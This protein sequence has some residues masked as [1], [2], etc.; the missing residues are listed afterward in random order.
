MQTKIIKLDTEKIDT[1]KVKEAAAV[2]D[3]GGLVAFPTETVYGIACQAKR[4]SLIRLNAIKKRNT[5]KPYSL[6][7]SQKNEVR[8]YVPTIGLKANKLIRNAWPGPLTIVF[9]LSEQD[10]N[11]QQKLLNKETIEN[12]YMNNSIGIRCPDNS[13]ASM[14]LHLV[15]GSVVAPSA[16]IADE[17]PATDAEQVLAKFSGQIELVLDAGPCRF[18]KSSTVVRIDKGKL[19]I[20]RS[21]FYTESDLAALSEVKFLFICTGNTCRSPMAEGIFRK[22]L[23]EK[24]EC[25]VDQLTKMGYKVISAGTINTVDSPASIEAIAACATRGVDITTH[26]SRQLSRQ[27]IEESDYIYG[28][29]QSHCEKVLALSRMTVDK[30]KLL[31]KDEEI[32]D[33]IG[34]TQKFFDRCAERIEKAVIERIFEIVI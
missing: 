32:H 27:L 9:E 2:V 10:I 22:Q 4:D 17:E 6:H 16:N 26:K 31:A 5:Q 23:A 8:K 28:M 29:T 11:K 14:L 25:N 20:L 7:I 21:G 24:L 30:C 34:Q 1:D 3:S 15:N 33:P 13:I 19:E 12:L 18:K